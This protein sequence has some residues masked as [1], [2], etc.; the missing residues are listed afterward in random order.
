[1][2]EQEMVEL[3]RE[4][5]Q[6]TREFVKQIGFLT[7]E[8]AKANDRIAELLVIV[9]RRRKVGR[10]SKPKL[11]DPPD[12]SDEMKSAF[13]HRPTPPAE[14]GKRHDH[15]RPRQRPTGRKPLPDHL[16]KDESERAPIRC[17]C[18]CEDFDW[19][20]EVVEEKLDIQAHQRRRVTR[21]KTGRCKR[22]MRR[23]TAEAPPSPFAR[24]KVTC[25]WLAWFITQK[26]QLLIP[27]DRIRL[28]LH[29]QGVPLSMSFLV[30]Q[31]AQA[32]RLLEA[33]DGE[34]WKQLLA[35]DLL[36]T[37]GTNLKVQIPKVGLHHGYIEAYLNGD[38]VV[39]H[40]EAEKGGE[41]QAAK[42]QSFSGTLMVD[43][44][45]RYNLTSASPTIR[46]ANCHAHPRRKLRDAEVMQPVLAKEG[47]RYISEPFAVDADGRDRGLEGA[48]WPGAESTLP[49]S[50]KRSRSGRMRSTRRCCRMTRWR[51]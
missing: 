35:G 37:D 22:C 33:I 2:R 14:R 39:F 45:S 42:L 19:V 18:G 43:A 11:T 15:P 26:F 9:E 4:S 13:D 51:R 6:Q 36:A 27:L 25:Q 30:S 8:V 41:T 3:R 24:S 47:G 12:L 31:T 48:S 29:G 32:T 49:R 7:Q 20:D 28:Q 21:R 46:E 10:K 1:M 5:A 23:T 44:E 50:W 34:H 38:I 16:P 17:R 40:Y